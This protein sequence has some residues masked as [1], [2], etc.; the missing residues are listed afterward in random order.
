[1][2]SCF[3]NLCFILVVICVDV[4]EIFNIWFIIVIGLLG[5]LVLGIMGSVG[6]YK[7]FY[8]CLLVGFDLGFYIWNGGV[9]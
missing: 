1:M 8:V 9:F 5:M 6:F 7:L 3:R 2:F 4:V